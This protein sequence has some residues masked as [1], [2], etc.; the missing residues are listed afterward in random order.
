MNEH[1]MHAQVLIDQDRFELAEEK[2]HRAI[3]D[4]PENALA[5][6]WLALALIEQG[7]RDQSVTA[8]RTGVRLDPE[9]AYAYYILAFIHYRMAEY[10]A[11][12]DALRKAIEIEPEEA[13]H[14]SLLSQ[15]A[16]M[17]RDWNSALEAADEGL[18]IDPEH[19]DSANLRAMALVRLGRALEAESTI[20]RALAHDPENATTQSNRGW[21]LLR[22]GQHETALGIFTEALRLDPAL[23]WAREG[24]VEALKSRNPL[25]RNLLRFGFWMSTL[26]KQGRW[27]VAIGALVMFRGLRILADS[28]PNWA[29][30]VWP[31]LGLYIVFAIMAWVGEPIANLILRLNRAGRQALSAEQIKATNWISGVLLAALTGAAFAFVTGPELLYLAAAGTVSM[32]VPV[33]AVFQAKRERTKSILKWYAIGLVVVGVSGL[34]LSGLGV[35]WD[36]ILYILFLIGWI[37]F[38]WT[39]NFLDYRN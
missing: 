12:L 16:I 4:E 34:L 26:S 29:V 38:T 6:A 15:I 13:D 18:T 30:I 5:H 24:L 23:N 11:A 7:K 1:L 32:M 22:H 20:D 31:L 37:A 28:Y 21:I 27:G 14:F 3:A 33:S 39:A 25:Y 36:Y 19:V 35:S 2:L 8:A 9:Y 17:E 10:P